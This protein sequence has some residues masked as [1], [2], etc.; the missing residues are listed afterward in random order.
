MKHKQNMFPFLL[1]LEIYFY[2]EY[3]KFLYFIFIATIIWN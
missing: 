1:K 3:I 2:F